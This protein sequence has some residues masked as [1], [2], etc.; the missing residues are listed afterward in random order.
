MISNPESINLKIKKPESNESKKKTSDA[1]QEK[2][3]QEWFNNIKPK[4]KKKDFKLDIKDMLVPRKKPSDGG[5]DDKEDE[6]SPSELRPN[7]TGKFIFVTN[8]SIK[9]SSPLR[10]R[11]R[12]DIEFKSLN[13]HDK[14]FVSHSKKFKLIESVR[15]DDVR[16]FRLIFNTFNEADKKSIFF[17]RDSRNRTLLHLACFYGRLK[18]IEYMISKRKIINDQLYSQCLFLK[19]DN[20]YLSIDLACVR[21]Y[22][23]SDDEYC[24]ASQFKNVEDLP[25]IIEGRASLRSIIV[26]ILLGEMNKAIQRGYKEVPRSVISRR[27]YVNTNCPLHWAIYWGDLQLSIILIGAQ[28]EQIFWVNKDDEIPFDLIND[29]ESKRHRV[30]ASLVVY[31]IIEIIEDRLLGLE[32]FAQEIEDVVKYLNDKNEKK[33]LKQRTRELKLQEKRRMEARKNKEGNIPMT[34]FSN[35][36]TVMIK[37]A[38]KMKKF[39]NENKR[40]KLEEDLLIDSTDYKHIKN[41]EMEVNKEIEERSRDKTEHVKE[42][43]MILEL[44]EFGEIEKKNSLAA[45]MQRSNSKFSAGVRRNSLSVGPVPRARPRSSRF[46]P[47]NL[48]QLELPS[49]FGP[50]QLEF[51]GRKRRNHKASRKSLI[52]I[53]NPDN[54]FKK[55]DTKFNALLVPKRLKF[56]ISKD[57]WTASNNFYLEKRLVKIKNDLVKF[58]RSK[59]IKDFNKISHS[60]SHVEEYE[61][62]DD[63]SLKKIRKKIKYKKLIYLQRVAVWYAYFEKLDTLLKMMKM[64][65][66]SPFM[67]NTSGKNIIHLLCYENRYQLLH[68]LIN[69][70]YSYIGQSKRFRIKEALEI[71][72]TKNLNTPAHICI[73]KNSPNIL[74]ILLEVGVN[75]QL[76]NQRGWSCSELFVKFL[77][78]NFKESKEKKSPTQIYISNLNHDLKDFIR[79]VLEREREQNIKK[80]KDGILKAGTIK[81]KD[82]KKWEFEFGDIHFDFVFKERDNNTKIEI[83]EGL[84]LYNMKYSENSLRKISMKEYDYCIVAVADAM[85]GDKTTVYKQ[86]QFLAETYQEDGGIELEIVPSYDNQ[87]KRVFE[88]SGGC[89]WAKKKLN[90]TRK[91]FYLIQI[92]DEL[93]NK[94]AKEMDLKGYNMLKSYSTQYP[95]SLKGAEHFEPLRDIQKQQVILYLLRQEFDLKEFRRNDL[96]KDHFPVNNFKKM[97]TVYLF[98]WNNR[99]KLLIDPI[100][101]LGKLGLLRPFVMIGNYNGLQNAYFFAFLNYY[102]SWILMLCIISSGVYIYGLVIGS[103]NNGFMPF[104]SVI[105][106]VW[107][108]FMEKRWTTREIELAHS[109]GTLNEKPKAVLRHAYTGRFKIDKVTNKVTKHNTFTAFKKRILV[110]NLILTLGLDRS[111]DIRRGFHRYHILVHV[112]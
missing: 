16:A 32:E 33:I 91:F 59:F 103:L 38:K 110:T 94:V 3:E 79:E 87:L 73:Y 48:N 47:D 72:I 75:L 26:R 35:F 101:R 31:V 5:E 1:P 10:E 11:Q 41:L 107:G 78:K 25:S 89:C 86:L 7:R 37:T 98:W 95:S 34:L 80:K 57:D 82:M 74:F 109:F 61:I 15:D 60:I 66:I 108:T 53:Q 49:S 76:I 105:V 64:F 9:N 8:N 44:S 13:T 27:N 24:T 39:V 77:N 20:N 65:K 23:V 43:K 54:I 22:S 97:K 19:D 111:T 67:R 30:T 29:I 58:E 69:I 62:V 36:S 84:N 50:K 81:L 92:S 40:V 51:K 2:Q 88:T 12:S 70:N 102:T 112:Y 46:R 96:L 6:G 55:Y 90:L 104:L 28:F 85:H 93:M 18:I 56:T 21:G 17:I 63:Y 52:P 45:K 4:K 68:Q 99:W 42:A 83:L 100:F 14:I 106:G 71:P